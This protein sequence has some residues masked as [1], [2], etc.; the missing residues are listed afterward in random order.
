MHL[1]EVHINW[2]Y[3]DSR[4]RGTLIAK[5]PQ[6]GEVTLTLGHETCRDILAGI[7]NSPT[8]LSL[9]RVSGTQLSAACQVDE[10]AF[11]FDNPF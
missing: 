10:R 5:L 6:V 4:W 1:K 3:M 11:E 8:I 9:A 2:S 7:A